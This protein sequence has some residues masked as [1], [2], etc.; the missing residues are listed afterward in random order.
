M[1]DK[2]LKPMDIEEQ[3]IMDDFL[4]STQYLEEAKQIPLE[5]LETDYEKE[6]IIKCR[7]NT[8]LN[9][10]ELT[11]LKQ[12]LAKYRGA[13]SKINP[14][15]VEENVNKTRRII[16]SEKELLKLI[17]NQEN[18]KL[19]MIYRL[20]SSEEVVLNLRVKPLTDSQAISEMQA[21]VDLFKELDTSERIVWNKAMSGQ[22]I[23][24]KEE[25]K[26]AE[27][28]LKK[29]EDKEFDMESKVN[30]MREFLARQVEF[31]EADFNTYNQKLKFW[32]RIEVQTIVD[33][34]NKVREILQLN[35][36]KTEDLFLN[37]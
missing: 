3:E 24:T 30:S 15:E 2:D 12:L 25:Q 26:L 20:P 32:K 14:S 1:V 18:Y 33:L 35:E 16:N 34:Y 21:H 10:K 19:E 28:V 6:L 37:G 22:K 17:D 13:L 11:D 36:I 23:I 5:I 8:N 31:V 9:D 7:E 29:Y 4:L 27:H